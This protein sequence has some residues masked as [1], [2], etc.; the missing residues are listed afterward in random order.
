MKTWP[1]PARE[2]Q[3]EAKLGGRQRHLGA[4]LADAV[5]GRIDL[6]IADG[7]A[8]RVGRRSRAPDGR[9]HS[10]HELGEL[11]GFRHVVVGPELEPHDHVERVAPRGEHHDRNLAVATDRPADLEAVE[12]REH[13]VEDDEVVRTASE[14][15]QAFTAVGRSRD[16]EARSL[17]PERRR[18]SDGRVVLD[19]EHALVHELTVGPRTCPAPCVTCSSRDRG[20]R[21]LPCH[22]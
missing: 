10:R 6:E 1:G 8:P 17:E 12:L 2:L 5:R 22:G 15:G 7:E 20:L 18:L 19:Q 4:R 9:A 3:Q 21:P 16:P 11:E 14:L 13:D